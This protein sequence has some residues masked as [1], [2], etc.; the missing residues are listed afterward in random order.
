M[1]FIRRPGAE[2]SRKMAFRVGG[3]PPR[4]FSWTRLDQPGLGLTTVW[5][6]KRF[7]A[8]RFHGFA[9]PS[10]M[11]SRLLPVSPDWCWCGR[12]R[13]SRP[14]GSSIHNLAHAVEPEGGAGG[15]LAGACAGATGA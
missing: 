15:A 10:K 7:E 6:F 9:P 2:E 8:V 12:K 14:V 11:K 1:D 5:P 3:V 4:F 13:R